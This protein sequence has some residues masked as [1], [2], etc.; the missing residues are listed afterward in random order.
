MSS[1]LV[2]RTLVGV[3]LFSLLG[4]VGAGVVSAQ[5][6]AGCNRNC[7]H[8]ESTGANP[9]Q[10][11]N[12]E[13]STWDFTV[14]NADPNFVCCR[15]ENVTVLMCCPGPNGFPPSPQCNGGTRNGQACGQAI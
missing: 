6:P 10:L 11:L 12:G 15:A 8:M 1:G 9:T 7:L 13:S 4:F 3:V 5:T 14:S 2:M